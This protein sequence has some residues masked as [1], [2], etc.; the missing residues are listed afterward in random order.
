MFKRRVG[1][2]RPSQVMHTFGVGSV[3]DLPYFS[4]IILGLHRWPEPQPKQILSEDRLLRLVR[5][6]LPQVEKL[7]VPPARSD[8]TKSFDPY[9]PESLRGIPVSPFP[10]WVR[11]P[12]CNLMA[13]LSSG[14]FELKGNPY[15]PD[16]TKYVHQNCPKGR[17]NFGPTVVPVR[18]I[19]VCEESGHMDDFPWDEY[20][21]GGQSCGRPL[22][23]FFEFGASAEATDIVVK[24]ETCGVSRPCLLYTSPSPRDR[25]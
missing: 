24:C 1:E 4:A 21:H 10:R 18:F 25:S 9:D 13:P 17:G 3:V 2:V 6:H 15:H 19:R 5:S 23:R 14:V 16:S 22:L 7:V 8:S 12:L 11:C 20:V